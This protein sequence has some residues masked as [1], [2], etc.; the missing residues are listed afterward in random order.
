MSRTAFIKKQV[1]NLKRKRGR[2]A[3]INIRTPLG[4]T[5][6]YQR[7]IIKTLQIAK[8]EIEKQIIPSLPYIM[9]E[10]GSL[11]PTNDDSEIRLDAGIADKISQLF[12]SVKIEIARRATDHAINKMVESYADAISNWNKAEVT[13]AF[14][15][16]MGIDLF[17]GEPY[18]AEELNVWTIQNANLVKDVSTQFVNQTEQ[19]VLDG[20]RRGV[21]HEQVAKQILGSTD[22]DKGR[23]KTAETRAKVIGRDQ[24]SKL[25]GTLNRLRQENA[26]V[27]KYIWRTVGDAR[28]RETHAMNNGREF[29]WREGWEGL[30]PGDDYNCRCFAEPIFTSIAGLE[31]FNF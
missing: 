25:N 7:A 21:R 16:G 31:D 26:G 18:L 19:I 4:L 15:S 12:K 14:K 6:D 3:T 30:H 13:S 28:V 22:L 23:F 27:T 9:R 20:I 11:R 1:A 2:K 8:E 29:T 17:Y 5:K 10:A 24:V